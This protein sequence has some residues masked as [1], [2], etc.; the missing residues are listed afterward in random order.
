MDVTQRAQRKSRFM[1]KLILFFAFIFSIKVAISQNL[2]LRLLKKMNGVNKPRWDN[3][4]WGWSASIFVTTPVTFVGI[5]LHGLAMRDSALLRNGFKSAITLGFAT[6]TTT[7]LKYSINRTRPKRKYPDEII[8]RDRAGEF[9]F[10]SGHTTTA[11]ATATAISLSYNKWY[12]TV[13]AYTYAAIVGYSRMRLG[14]HFGSD[15]LGGIVVGLGS[16]LLVW[17]VDRWMAR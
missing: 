17:Q 2:D 15:V 1:C 7:T 14:M 6:I 13:P 10:P 8:E 5:P 9:S 12:V 11:F 3:I 16:G 4:M